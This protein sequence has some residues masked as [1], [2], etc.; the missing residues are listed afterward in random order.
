M[1]ISDLSDN[2]LRFWLGYFMNPSSTLSFGGDHAETEITPEAR[3]ALDELLEVGAAKPIPPTD[4]WPDREYYGGTELDLRSE[5]KAR[6][7]NPFDDDG[8]F[9]TFRKKK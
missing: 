5:M 6:E 2:A 9:V 4:G 3:E 7:I 1:T 8:S